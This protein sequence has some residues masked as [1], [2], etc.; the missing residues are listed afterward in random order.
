MASRAD[1]QGNAVHWLGEAKK[2]H[3]GKHGVEALFIFW[4]RGE[5]ESSAG[6]ATMPTHELKRVLQ[7][8][9]KKIDDMPIIVTPYGRN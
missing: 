4:N 9:L 3:L 6:A 8:L 5:I 2:N 1:L 7:V